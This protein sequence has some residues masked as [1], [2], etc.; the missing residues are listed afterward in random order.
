MGGLDKLKAIHSLYME[1]VAVMGNGNEIT[2]KIYKVQDKLYRR[3]VD[4]GMGSFTSI[5]TD[6]GGWFSNP[7]NGGAFEEMPAEMLKSQQ[8]E[9][10]CAGPLV[11]YAAKGN[12]VELMGMEKVN[13]KDCY[14]IKL[15]TAAGR[16]FNYYIDNQDFYVVRMSFKG[17]GMM[18]GGRRQGAN[19]DAE[20][21]VDYSDYKKDDAGY[22]FPYTVS[23]GGMMGKLNYEKIQVNP[24]IDEK[25]YKPDQG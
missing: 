13:G 20:T 8:P 19:P 5:V 9:M 11:D 6:K 10:D 17:G 16:E 15:T 24:V 7:R 3:D 21:N 18:G 4:F 23:M 22:V 1:G 12:K 25:L 2:T 14:K